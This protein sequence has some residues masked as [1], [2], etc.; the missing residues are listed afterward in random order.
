M[1]HLQL[2]FPEIIFSG[3][4]AVTIII[5][6]IIIIISIIIIIIIWGDGINMNI[7]DFT[8]NM[9]VIDPRVI[10]FRSINWEKLYHTRNC[11]RAIIVTE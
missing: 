2:L 11:T 9:F 1:L 4:I 6:I 10:S 8:D 3:V 7:F 5:I